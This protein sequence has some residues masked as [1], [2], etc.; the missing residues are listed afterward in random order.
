MPKP[1]AAQFTKNMRLV[2]NNRCVLTK[3]EENRV[4]KADEV[5]KKWYEKGSDDRGG[6][7]ELCTPSEKESGVV[8]MIDDSRS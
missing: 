2:N 7:V 4:T 8:E 5:P 1:R 6:K 3:S